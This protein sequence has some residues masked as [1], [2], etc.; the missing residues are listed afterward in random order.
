MA[1][2]LHTACAKSR[3]V[4]GSLML[5][6]QRLINGGAIAGQSMR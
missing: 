1:F 2:S 3:V 5:S 4:L 6:P